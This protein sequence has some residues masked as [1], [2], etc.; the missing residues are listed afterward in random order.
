[1]KYYVFS[2]VETKQE[3]EFMYSDAE[4]IIKCILK[5]KN[6]CIQLIKITKAT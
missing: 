2:K 4:Y 6:R 5:K 3:C 1:M